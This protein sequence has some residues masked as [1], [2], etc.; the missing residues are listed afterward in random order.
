MPTY[1]YGCPEC[2]S[3]KEVNH[4]VTADPKVV[5]AEC[6]CPMVRRPQKPGGSFKG[7]GFYTTDKFN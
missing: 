2:G 6:P 4:S 1:L 7:E 5:C 3:T